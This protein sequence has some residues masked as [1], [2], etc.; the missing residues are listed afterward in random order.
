ML[1]CD[2][3]LII[4]GGNDLTKMIKNKK[5]FYIIGAVLLGFYAGEDEKILNFPFRVNVL[6]YASSLIITLGYFHFSNRKKA[7]YSFVMEF[8]S[9]LAIA[10]ALF[11]MIRIGFLFYIKKAADR[12]VS[13]M[14][15]PVYNFVSGRRNSVYFYF[16][17]Q[18]YSLGYRNNQQLDR[19]DI[20]KNYEVELEYSRS[21][22]D[23]YVIWRYRITPKK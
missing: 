22:L 8:L 19:E 6:L 4:F 9:S 2:E 23:T 13:I 11:L 7:G 18:R 21:V 3:N 17:N 14:R 1:L 5:V 20:I 10:F 15:C 12:D 16:H